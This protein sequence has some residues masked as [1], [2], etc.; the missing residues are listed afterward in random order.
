M[1]NLDCCVYEK[2]IAVYEYDPNVGEYSGWTIN[3]ATPISFHAENKEDIE[4]EFHESVNFYLDS[5]KESGL[6]PKKPFIDFKNIGGIAQDTFAKVLRYCI[7][8]KEII[9]EFIDKSIKNTLLEDDI[10]KSKNY[11][12]YNKSLI[13]T[14]SNNRNN[15]SWMVSHQ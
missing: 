12:K 6:E 15:F 8:N 11:K 7:Q 10:I 4:K 3:S 13:I 14:D 5:C 9:G 1:N 2:Y